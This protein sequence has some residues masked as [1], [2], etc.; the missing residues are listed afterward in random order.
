[1]FNI[2]S[3]SLSLSVCVCVCVCVCMKMFKFYLD[4]YFLYWRGI[5]PL[6]GCHLYVLY[7]PYSVLAVVILI[8]LFWLAESCCVVTHTVPP[9]SGDKWCY[10][11][12]FYA[13][14]YTISIVVLLKAVVLY[15]WCCTAWFGCEATTPWLSCT[16]FCAR[17]R[18][19]TPTQLK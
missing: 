15:S 18:V 6:A 3:L 7:M 1:M 4:C 17:V 2:P 19:G 11:L 16:L 9:F 13:V 14:L 8:M 10:V 12:F 5:L